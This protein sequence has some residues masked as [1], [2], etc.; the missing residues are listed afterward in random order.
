M[1]KRTPLSGVGISVLSLLLFYIAY[2]YLFFVNL[3]K[4][5]FFGLMLW[6]LFSGLVVAIYVHLEMKIGLII[7]LVCYIIGFGALFVTFWNTDNVFAS[8]T[9]QLLFIYILFGGFVVS[10]VVELVLWL[11]KR[12]KKI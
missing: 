7:F 8:I 3:F 10:L 12:N 1:K 11:M 9:G 5:N 2:R 4:E 6:S